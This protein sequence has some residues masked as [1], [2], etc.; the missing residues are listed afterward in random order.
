MRTLMEQSKD[1][2]V[3]LV[4]GV[5]VHPRRRVGARPARSRG[6]RHPH[7]GRGPSSDA[8]PAG[9]PRSTPGASARWCAEPSLDA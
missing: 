5:K 9:W 7:L 4:D 3:E 8:E 1:R 6:A 2:E